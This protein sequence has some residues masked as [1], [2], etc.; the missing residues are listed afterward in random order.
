MQPDDFL[1]KYGVS[2]SLFVLISMGIALLLFLRVTVP[3]VRRLKSNIEFERM[4][5]DAAE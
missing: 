2:I 4:F 5:G 1:L 3:V